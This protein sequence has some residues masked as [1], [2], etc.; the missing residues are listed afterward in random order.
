MKMR[1]RGR[2]ALFLAAC[3]LSAGETAWAQ[4]ITSPEE[5]FGF[6]MGSDK[7]MARWDKLVEYYELLEKQAKNRVKV[8]NMGPTTMGNPFLCVIV[9][10][11]A[12]MAK[13]ERLREINQKIV[14]PRGIGEEEIKR[15]VGEGK[16]V[17]VQSMSLHATEVGGS[18]MAPELVYDQVARQDDEAKRIRD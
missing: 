3:V 6:R 18:Q 17:V 5:F 16:A 9:T 12:N 11:P 13:L 8:V 15:L 14:D 4:K 10:S 1:W 7:Q 2:L